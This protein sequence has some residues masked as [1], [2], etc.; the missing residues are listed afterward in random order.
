VTAARTA[1]AKAARE[2][3]RDGGADLQRFVNAGRLASAVSHDLLS[4]L[5]VAQTDV[6]FLCELFDQPERTRDLR[7]AADDA[8]VAISRAVSRIAAVLSLARLRAGEV[9]PLDVK[10]VIGAALFDLDARLAGYLVLREIMP[11]PF[12]L[13]E[14]GALLQTLVSVLLDAADATPARGRIGLSLR[15]ESG[16]VVVA[17]DDEG[18]A[19]I[20][21][22]ALADR[23][24][25]TLWIC[26]NV[27]RSFGGEL[28]TCPGPLGGKRV[29]LRL[30]TDR[31]SP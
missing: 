17:I 31:V 13:A 14:R 2:Q 22:E 20:A 10:E 9:A 21:P 30:R 27:M 6:A 3:P 11:V 1:A 26:R 29:T 23:P 7:E 4:A 19:P 8:R 25:S 15:P 12:A 16:W 24:N 28:L 5:G 18:P